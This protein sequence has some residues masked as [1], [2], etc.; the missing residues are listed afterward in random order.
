[1]KRGL[2]VMVVFPLLK[3]H[4]TTL[5]KVACFTELL[6]GWVITDLHQGYI[7]E[8]LKCNIVNFG[9]KYVILYWRQVE[10]NEQCA[11]LIL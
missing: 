3:L 11:G 1:M 4:K 10:Y 2:C 5:P 9:F 8:V 7:C 6:K